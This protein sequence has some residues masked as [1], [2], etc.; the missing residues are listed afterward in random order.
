MIVVNE[1]REIVGTLKTLC[2][3]YLLLRRDFKLLTQ[4]D[5]Y[6]FNVV[7]DDGFEN[8]ITVNG[9]FV[10]IP[11]NVT[12]MIDVRRVLTEQEVQEVDTSSL[13][14]AETID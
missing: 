5:L 8:W 2:G 4:S 13:V 7:D 9:D 11:L 3:T 14:T 6:S 1:K 10:H 12:V